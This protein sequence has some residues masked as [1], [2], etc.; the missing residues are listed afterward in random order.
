VGEEFRPFARISGE[1]LETI[2]NGLCVGR[3]VWSEQLNNYPDDPR[4]QK[5]LNRQIL[6]A[7]D[8]ML[9]I[10][11][12]LLSQGTSVEKNILEELKSLS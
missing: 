5:I 3:M 1:N 4:I 2:F 10:L 8:V 12:T 11:P 9:L 7:T 6:N